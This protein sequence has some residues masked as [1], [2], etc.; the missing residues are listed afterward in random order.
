MNPSKKKLASLLAATA[1][2]AA[3]CG[4]DDPVDAIGDVADDAADVVDDAAGDVV[5]DATDTVDDVVDDVTDAVAGPDGLQLT[6]AGLEPL[7]EG[8]VY[9]GWVVVDGTPVS[10]GRFN[11]EADGSQSYVSESLVEDYESATDFVLTIEPAEGD[12]P[13]PAA[14]KPLAGPIVDGEA[15]LTH[16]H[17]AALGEDFAA[18]G[19]FIIT[20]PTTADED[21]AK[22]G[23]W[24]LDPTGEDGPAAS[25]QLS[26]LPE[27]WVYEGW[28]VTEEGPLSTG[29]FTSAEGADDFDGFS[30]EEA[31]PPF[32]GEDFIVNAPEGFE[33]PVD[34]SNATVVIS[35]E[36]ADDDSPAP[37]AFKP[38]VTENSDAP[39]AP[40][41]ID[42]GEGVFPTGTATIG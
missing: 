23:V 25:L 12:D 40:E 37:F 16:L 22:Y 5:D 3:A 18:A 9:E 19:Q 4:S 34:V 35:I 36:P 28:V 21:D 10:T 42:L 15:Q 29:R 24:F 11:L 2:F 8:F 30:G 1:V 27:G 26:E 14:A 13:A 7:G 41:L 31:G 32:P 17:P 20:T 39:V 38:L 6:F 33:F